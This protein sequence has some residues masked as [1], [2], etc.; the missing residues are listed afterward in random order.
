MY[1]RYS[2]SSGGSKLG[3]IVMALDTTRY[4]TRMDERILIMLV[5]LVIE[6]LIGWIIVKWLSRIYT[7]PFTQLA[8]AIES[9]DAEKNKFKLVNT[10]AKNEI[11]VLYDGYN[12]MIG[13]IKHANSDLKKSLEHVKLANSANSA[14]SS[15]LANMSHEIRTPLTAIIG[16][17]ESLLDSDQNKNERVD[18]VNTII[19]AGK[20]LQHIVND[21]LDLSKVEAEKLEVELINVPLF[22]LIDDVS[23]LAELQTKEKGILFKVEC[24]WPLP[25]SIYSDPIRLKQILINLVNNAVKFTTKGS[26]TLKVSLQNDNTHIRFDIIDTGIGIEVK[27]QEKLFSAFTQAEMSTSRRYGGTGLGLCLSRALA[28]MLGGDVNFTSEANKGSVFS[29]TINAS[30]L[31][32]D[33][34]IYKMPIVVSDT[35]S[36]KKTQKIFLSGNILLAEDNEDNQKLISMHIKKTGANVDIVDNG[37]SVVKSAL[38]NKYDLILM[39]IQMPLMDGLEATNKLR[40]E[41]YTGIIVALTAN[42]MKSDIDDCIAAGCNQFLAKPINK[43]EFLDV[44]SKYLPNNSS[45]TL[46]L[47][48][49]LLEEDPDFIDLVQKFVLNFPI[50]IS[51]TKQ[52]FEEANWSEFKNK[53]QD[54]KAL[55]GNFGFMDITDVAKQIEVDLAKHEFDKVG[56]G[57]AKLHLLSDRIQLGIAA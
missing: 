4:Q 51:A 47:V 36:N 32:L 29:V 34:L 22:T 35:Y 16:F 24:I 20:H 42:A 45:T 39:D 14:K 10:E 27:N 6:L 12:K 41:G 33:H 56:Q 23:R 21:I 30:N 26:V 13:Q 53:I 28:K 43:I 8:G 55:G 46:P 3:S 25:E 5:L 38:K 49:T 52:L 31:N 50:L 9:S 1:R 57:I 15:F 18:S 37:I 44:L 54:L 7:E 2:I 11:K 48:S 40:D 17:S 19:K